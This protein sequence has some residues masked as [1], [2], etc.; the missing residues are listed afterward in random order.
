MQ[1]ILLERIEKLGALGDVVAVKPGFARNYLLPQKKA[2]RATKDNIAYFEGQKKHL[3]AEND[4]RK[5]EAEKTA[6]TVNGISVI[7]IRQASEGGQLYGSVASRDI[8]EIVNAKLGENTIGKQHVVIDR[9]YKTLGLFDIKIRLHAE[10][11]CTITVNIARSEE[12][13]KMQVERGEA[14][15]RE[16]AEA[17]LAEKAIQ[18]MADAEEKAAAEAEAESESD[19]ATSEEE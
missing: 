7:L 1:V 8:S 19:A 5:T 13:A 11:S 2:M 3:V 4:K 17:A 12:E 18:A 16:E 15:I 6:K 9:N 14:L 10:V